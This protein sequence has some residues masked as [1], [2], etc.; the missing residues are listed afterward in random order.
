MGVKLKISGADLKWNRRNQWKT[1]VGAMIVGA[2]IAGAMIVGAM[3]VGAL[4]VG[5]IIVRVM[6]VVRVMR[7]CGENHSEFE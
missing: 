3:I 6:V 1:I 7:L 5:A 4:I 2:M